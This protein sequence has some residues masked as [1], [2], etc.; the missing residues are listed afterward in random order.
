MAAVVMLGC[1]IGKIFLSRV[2]S[3]I[4]FFIFDLVADI[5]ISHFH[6][7]GALFFDHAVGNAGSGCV[8]AV[9]GSRGLRMPQ[10][11]KGEAKNAALFCV[12]EE[13]P[14]LSFGGGS[15]YKF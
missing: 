12:H 8:V 14:E 15:H 2:P 13:C 6:G 11:L 3:H 10:F 1:I 7:S 9:D 4:K 5:E